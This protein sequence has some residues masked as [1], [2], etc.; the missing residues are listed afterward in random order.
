MDEITKLLVEVHTKLSSVQEDVAHIKTRL[1]PIEDDYKF[2]SKLR[3][4]VL[5]GSG[6]LALVGALSAFVNI[7]KAIG[8]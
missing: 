3:S 6:L 2:R 7:A 1:T 5:G 4:A 8:H